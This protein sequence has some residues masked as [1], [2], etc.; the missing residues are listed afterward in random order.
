MRVRLANPAGRELPRHASVGPMH[1]EYTARDAINRYPPGHYS[2]I[3][4]PV[5]DAF[6]LARPGGDSDRI[7]PSGHVG[8]RELLHGSEIGFG[9]GAGDSLPAR[10][11]AD[12]R[13]AVCGDS[14]TRLGRPTR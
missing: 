8:T 1:K 12:S 7:Q 3:S 9:A 5:A 2:G 6:Q 4:A 10:T 11:T 13:R 14:R